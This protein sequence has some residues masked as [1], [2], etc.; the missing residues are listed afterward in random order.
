MRTNSTVLLSDEVSSL[1]YS[2]IFRGK[3]I[4]VIFAWIAVS[5]INYNIRFVLY[6]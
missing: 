2:K 4:Y 5:T 1:V 3:E 6:Q